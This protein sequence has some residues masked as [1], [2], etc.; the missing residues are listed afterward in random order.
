MCYLGP[1]EE[2]EIGLGLGSGGGRQQELLI[3]EILRKQEGQTAI[4]RMDVFVCEQCNCSFF[5]ERYPPQAHI[6]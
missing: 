1:D 2:K 4:I 5:L 6:L 3:M